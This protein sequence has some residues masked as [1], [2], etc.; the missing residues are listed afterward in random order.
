MR[1]AADI[2]R[3]AHLRARCGSRKPGA[4]RI[5]GRG[6]CFETFPRAT[7]P[8][9][10]PTSRIVGSGPNATVLHYRQNNQQMEDGELLLIDAGCEYDYYA[11]D[12]TRTFP[13]ERQVLAASSGRSTSSCSSAGGGHRRRRARGARSSRSTQTCVE[14]ITRRP[15]RARASCRAR[16]SKLIEDEAYKPFYMHRTSHWLGMD[17]HDVGAT[18]ST[19]RAAAARAGHGA[20]RRAGHL[21]RE[22]LTTRSAGVPRHRRAHRGRHPRHRGRHGNLT[23]DIPKTVASSNVPLPPDARARL[24]SNLGAWFD[25]HRRDCPGE[26]RGTRTRSGSRR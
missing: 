1:R 26:R 19:A 4:L 15:R 16:S 2:T 14:V 21:H 3:D 6:D 25:A 9:A 11:C 24:V 8:S 12:V 17:V 22:R 18:T 5:R 13:V 10:P 20:H 7:A 23:E